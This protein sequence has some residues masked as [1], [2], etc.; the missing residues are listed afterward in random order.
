ML[1]VTN[2][3]WNVNIDSGF[4]PLAVPRGG[5]SGRAALQFASTSGLHISSS[6]HA[7]ASSQTTAGPGAEIDEQADKTHNLTDRC[8]ERDVHCWYV[9][10]MLV[11]PQMGSCVY[12]VDTFVTLTG[13]WWTEITHF[14]TT[15][16]NVGV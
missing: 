3:L 2:K 9:K 6:D 11:I 14:L 15:F 12:C 4:N 16:K 5:S 8:S 1:H 10:D 13:E 7:A